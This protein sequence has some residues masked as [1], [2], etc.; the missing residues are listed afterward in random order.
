MRSRCAVAKCRIQIARAL[1][2][3]ASAGVSQYLD[4]ANSEKCAESEFKPQRRRYFFSRLGVRCDK[5]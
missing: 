2:L 3:S 5:T 1:L 4:L